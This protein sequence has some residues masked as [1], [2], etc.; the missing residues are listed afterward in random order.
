MPLLD[1]GLRAHHTAVCVEDFDSAKQFYIDFLGCELEGEMDHRN[2][3][4]LGEVVGLPGADIRWAM[5][6]HGDYRLEL[7]KYYR[8]EG[9]TGER[10]QCDVGYS[11]VAFQVDN[12][13]AVYE[14]AI[15]AGHEAL[16]APRDLRGGRTRVFYL[17]A[18]E[19]VVTEFIE[20]RPD[21]TQASNPNT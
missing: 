12:V 13:D 18:P 11:H 10:R 1:A 19:G 21:M 5:L 7:F 9:D 14:Q 8:P 2:E 20:L 17:K 4:A 3:T 15:A 16:S 6:R